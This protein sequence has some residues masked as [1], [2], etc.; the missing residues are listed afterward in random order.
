[1]SCPTQQ[2]PAIVLVVL[3]VN[4]LAS[5]ASLAHY[6]RSLRQ[7]A[8]LLT[9]PWTCWPRPPR[10]HYC[11][12]GSSPDCTHPEGSPFSLPVNLSTEKKISLSRIMHRLRTTASRPP[13]ADMT[14]VEAQACPST[15]TVAYAPCPPFLQHKPCWLLASRIGGLRET[16]CP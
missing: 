11:T 6:Y 3:D 15:F 5:V 10:L 14:R 4:G 2:Q 13:D 16:L 8:P 1:M 12:Q 9:L 7:L